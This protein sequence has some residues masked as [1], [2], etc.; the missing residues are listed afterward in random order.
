[1]RESGRSRCKRVSW[2]LEGG[3]LEGRG[4]KDM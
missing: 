4:G 2:K 1:M 3:D